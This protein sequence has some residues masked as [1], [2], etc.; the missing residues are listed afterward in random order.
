[1]V[2]KNPNHERRLVVH[3]GGTRTKSRTF[4]KPYFSGLSAFWIWSVG[5]PFLSAINDS[6][7]GL[8]VVEP[9]IP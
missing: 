7:Q 1:M 2:S 4:G 6:F 8:R 3:S 5:N 9:F